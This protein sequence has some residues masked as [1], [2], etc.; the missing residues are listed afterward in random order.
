MATINDVARRV[1]V[2]A[3][4]VSYVV[5]G[6]GAVGEKTR[7]RV[8]AAI[9]ELGYQPNLVARGLV[10]RRVYTLALVLVTITNP[11]YPEVAAEVERIAREHGYHLVLCN[12]YHDA[13]IGRA[14]LDDMA[15]R[16]VDGLLVMSG[17]LDMSDLLTIAP[18]VPPT[19]LVLTDAA[20]ADLALPHVGVD[21][22]RAGEQAA[23]HLLDLGHRRVAVIAQLPAHHPRLDGYR[24]TLAASGLDLFP[25]FVR[26]GESTAESGYHAASDLLGQADRPTAIFATNDLMALGAMEA[27]LDGGLQVP[28]DLSIIGLDDIALGMHVRPA[29]TTVAIPKRQLAMEATEMLLRDIERGRY[30]TPVPT[31]RV[32]QPHLV[33]R[34]STAAPPKVRRPCRP[35]ALD[36][37]KEE[38]RDRQV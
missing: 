17:S 5:T 11:F 21:V 25:A 12:T 15:G 19:V 30:D 18:P 10:R 29:L 20:V 9:E 34:H 38:R 31:S 32:V 36:R 22:R 24:D 35:H 2:T 33:I 23:R 6:K 4:T 28:R 13:A 16:M 8:Q 14:Y 27:A 3:A 1:G 26:E 7:A 37:P